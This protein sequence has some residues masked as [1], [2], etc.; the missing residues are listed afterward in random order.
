MAFTISDGPWSG[1]PSSHDDGGPSY[2]SLHGDDRDDH[3]HAYRDDP[4]D[5]H[6]DVR[7]RGVPSFRD[8]G[9][10][11]QSDGVLPSCDV[12]PSHRDVRDDVR[13][14]RDVHRGDDHR[15]ICVL[16]GTHPCEP[17]CGI[18]GFS[19][20]SCDPS[21]DHVWIHDVCAHARDAH[22][23]DH[24]HR[25]DASCAHH[26]HDDV[27]LRAFCRNACDH[28]GDDDDRDD[29]P[30][31][32]FPRVRRGDARDARDLRHPP[33]DYCDD[34]DDWPLPPNLLRAHLSPMSM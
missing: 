1:W 34:D 9:G 4:Y 16:C 30:C 31:H 17:S 3:G 23:D 14:S 11:G 5:L 22:H 10:R 26:V 25:D 24:A 13:V 19:L 6:R 18:R 15:R 7:D 12:L 33:R 32:L 27:L 8:D 29:G 20:P 21:C 2:A 28:H